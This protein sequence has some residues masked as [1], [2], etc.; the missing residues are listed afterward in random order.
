MRNRFDYG[1]NGAGF[2]ARNSDLPADEGRA[3]ATVG[4]H[5]SVQLDGSIAASSFLA[6]R[7]E[8]PGTSIFSR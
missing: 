1:P 6:R 7:E 8:A 2:S 3:R 5:D 4:A